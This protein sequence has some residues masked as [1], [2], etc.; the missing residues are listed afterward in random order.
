MGSK[1]LLLPIRVIRSYIKRYYTGKR[2]HYSLKFRGFRGTHG[3]QANHARNKIL[4][5]NLKNLYWNEV[6]VPC[7]WIQRSF[8]VCLTDRKSSTMPITTSEVLQTPFS[9]EL[10]KFERWDSSPFAL[11]M[12]YLF[13]F[14][15]LTMYN[16]V[17]P[18]S[19]INHRM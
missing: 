17:A 18:W 15:T 12:Y 9:Q 5:D 4:Y 2:T 8:Q 19:T 6:R 7:F 1:Y 11:Q 10:S 14:Y 3:T 13:R 16:S